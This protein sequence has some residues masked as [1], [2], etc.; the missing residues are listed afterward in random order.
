MKEASS[1]PELL[2]HVAAAMDICPAAHEGSAAR[3]LQRDRDWGE[4]GDPS[5]LG[6]LV[7]AR[8]FNGA[9][10]RSASR[11][12]VTPEAA[13]TSANA[14]FTGVYRPFGS[15]S[16]RVYAQAEPPRPWAEGPDTETIRPRARSA[17]DV[18]GL[19]RAPNLGSG[20]ELMAV[21][22]VGKVA[23]AETHEGAEAASASDAVA[24]NT[25]KTSTSASMRISKAPVFKGTDVKKKRTRSFGAS[26]SVGVGSNAMAGAANG[27][28]VLAQ[29]NEAVAMSQTSTSTAD[30]WGE[31]WREPPGRN[32]RAVVRAVMQPQAGAVGATR[33]SL[34]QQRATQQQQP[35]QRH[36]RRLQT[37]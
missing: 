28:V 5:G 31:L 36:R 8:A 15:V 4:T 29:A 21:L 27:K 30:Q 6:G 20:E 1:S 19:N 12:A 2:P 26:S 10:A 23:L 18:P 11:T 33:A 22:S 17:I 34:G 3:R 37:G 24:I 13:E 32:L 9:R 35:W 14:V 7:G 16:D 25:G